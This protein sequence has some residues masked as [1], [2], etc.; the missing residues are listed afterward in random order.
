MRAVDDLLDYWMMRGQLM[1]LYPV[2]P[3]GEGLNDA[4]RTVVVQQYD[5]EYHAGWLE[6]CRR[7][8]T[9]WRGVQRGSHGWQLVGAGDVVD[10]LSAALRL[11]QSSRRLCQ[12]AWTVAHY[13]RCFPGEVNWLRLPQP[14]LILFEMLRSQEWSAIG[15]DIQELQEMLGP[16]PAIG[17]IRQR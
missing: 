8:E 4:Q 3:R 14:P 2:E 7:L 16:L 17:A 12:T 15:L 5:E 1:G 9:L 11:E 6:S 10:H 13:W